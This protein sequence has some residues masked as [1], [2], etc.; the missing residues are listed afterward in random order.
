MSQQP[1]GDIPIFREL[2]RLLSSDEGPVNLELARQ[3]ADSIANEGTQEPPP[4]RDLVT[5]YPRSVI[6]AHQL[7]SGYTRLQIDELPSA[8]VIGRSAWVAS[9]LTGWSWLTE[10][11]AQRFTAMADEGNTETEAAPGM[12]M[13]IKQ[14]IPFMMGLQIGTLVGHLARET[15]S[16]YELPIP[17]SDNGRLFLVGQNADTVATDYGFDRNDFVM[18]IALRE[19]GRHMIIASNPWVE[20]YFR[21]S[22]VEVI[23][24]IEIDLGD[25]ERQMTE[26]GAGMEGLEGIGSEGMLP[27]VHTPRYES[28]LGRVK[29]LFAVFEGYASH[30]SGQ[31]STEVVPNVARIDEGMRRHA[32]VPSSGKQALAS[33]LGLDLDRETVDAG[34]TFCAA[35]VQLRGMG[36]LNEVWAAPDNLPSLDEIRDPFAWMERVLD[37]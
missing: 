34:A 8:E 15:L 22:L 2:Q 32:S 3:I 7:L 36:S 16:R 10:A 28:A 24:S 26:L 27:V 1:F 25:I 11:F 17:R 19:V 14:I 18:W 9:T 30:A 13:A 6:T 20:R 35:V 31:V 5:A 29:A 4:N 33:V 23:G 37:A 12:G 21:S